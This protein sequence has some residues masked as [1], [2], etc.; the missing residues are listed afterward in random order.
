MRRRASAALPLA[1]CLALTACGGEDAPSEEE[2]EPTEAAPASVEVSGKVGEK[3]TI[4]IPDSEP[5]PTLE[6]ED[7]VPGQGKEAKAGDTLEVNY[8][9][10]LYATG[11]EFDSSF[12]RRPFK[13]ELGRGMVIPGWDQGLE[14]LQEGGRRLLTIPPE[15]AYGE[16]GAPPVIGPNETLVFV[17]DLEKIS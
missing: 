12:E 11:E 17:V 4:E 13:F 5:P 16:Q 6:T 8:V 15:L 2:A 10:V 9:G 1:L 3:P 14:G 7:I